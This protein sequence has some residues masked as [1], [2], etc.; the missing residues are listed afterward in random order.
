MA[1]TIEAARV[2]TKYKFQ[3]SIIYAGLTGE[4]QVLFGGKILAEFVNSESCQINVVLS[5]DIIGN[6]EGINSVIDNT[7]A[8]VFSEGT[9]YVETEREAQARRFTGGEVDSPSR[10]IARYVDKM[11]DLYIPNL[12]VMMIYRLDRFG[13]GGHHRPF[14]EAGFPAVRI[15]ETNEN[16]NRQHQDI[17]TENGIKYGDTIDGVDFDYAAKL[18]ALNAVVMAGMAAAQK[19]VANLSTH[20]SSL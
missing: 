15:M 5:I 10:N 13:R 17:R 11:V 18:T 19:F 20:E 2:F 6:I 4:E 7:T 12:D 14:N 3:S 9:R 16:Y 8:R 1:G